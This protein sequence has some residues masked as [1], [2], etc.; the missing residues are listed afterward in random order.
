MTMPTP[1]VPVSER[2]WT[3]VVKSDD[4]WLWTAGHTPDGYGMVKVYGRHHGAHRVSWTLTNG[5]IPD[6]LAVLHRC[7]NPP[8]CRPDHLFLG[9]LGDNNR[10]RASKGRSGHGGGRRRKVPQA[11]RDAIRSIYAAGGVT[12]KELGLRYGVTAM[13]VTYIIREVTG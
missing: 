10:D 7:D 8:C 13:G 1:R 5:P 11:D 3:K 6:G 2:F 4:C 12:K 9:T